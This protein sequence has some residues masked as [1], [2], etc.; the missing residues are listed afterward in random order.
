MRVDGTVTE[1]HILGASVCDALAGGSPAT[2]RCRCGAVPR[3][4]TGCQASS[5]GGAPVAAR[6]THTPLCRWG[7]AGRG[8]DASS[9]WAPRWRRDLPHYA[10]LL[11]RVLDQAERRVL[12]GETVPTTDKIACSSLTRTSCA[13]AVA[14]R[15]T[16]TSQPRHRAQRA[17][18]R[19]RDNCATDRIRC[20]RAAHWHLEA[21]IH[22]LTTIAN[23]TVPHCGREIR[24]YGA[25][26]QHGIVGEYSIRGPTGLAARDF[27]A[28]TD[29]GRDRCRLTFSFNAQLATENPLH[30]G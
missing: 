15:S 3:S 7:T 23:A 18:A 30:L 24:L 1:T 16:A 11:R 19:N 21:N 10:D 20:S 9:V 25:T 13:R 26:D 28:H 17:G 22:Q 6:A 8:D 2:T 14:A 5:P 12:R 4:P 29:V 27:R